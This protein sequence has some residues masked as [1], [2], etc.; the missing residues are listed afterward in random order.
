MFIS[1]P[2]EKFQLLEKKA[3]T[4]R[5]LGLISDGNIGYSNS[6]LNRILDL[7]SVRSE[8]HTCLKSLD[9]QERHRLANEC[10]QL[11][12][13]DVLVYRWM[14]GEYVFFPLVDGRVFL[15][16][17]Q[18]Y[19][20]P[21]Y[22]FL[23]SAIRESQTIDI[24]GANSLFLGGRDSFGHLLQD[25]LP[26]A[27]SY[28]CH[29]EPSSIVLLPLKQ[30]LPLLTDSID[31]LGKSVEYKLLPEIEKGCSVI[32][33][34]HNISYIDWCAPSLHYWH[35]VRQIRAHSRFIDE[36][37]QDPL[38]LSFTKRLFWDLQSSQATSRVA[39]ANVVKEHLLKSSDDHWADLSN[40]KYKER[41]T[42]LSQFRGCILQSGSSWHNIFF[43][44][45]KN[46]VVMILNPSVLGSRNEICYH[47]LGILL[48]SDLVDNISFS[49]GSP[50]LDDASNP[51]NPNDPNHE[52]RRRYSVDP[53][54]LTNSILI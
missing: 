27:I 15:H 1:S 3:A 24:D 49:V 13:L 42:L 26:R 50:D 34:L 30:Y 9:E 39:N 54:N 32:Y 22:F 17:T 16:S 47:Q 2:E 11:D 31:Q 38:N 52:W 43:T 18:H 37:V 36:E 21:Y 29:T 19:W 41:R 53:H 23:E 51:I 48:H 6:R 20:V 33:R 28:C 4:S 40:L 7:N 8:I 14:T 44:H 5:S 46:L 25:F 35:A 10:F 45:E 12:H